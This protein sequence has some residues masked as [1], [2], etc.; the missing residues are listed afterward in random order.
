MTQDTSAGDTLT[1]GDSSAGDREPHHGDGDISATAT[2]VPPP[3]PNP[4]IKAPKRLLAPCHPLSP[5]ASLR[6]TPSP[7]SHLGATVPRCH[8]AAI[9]MSP[10]SHLGATL[11]SLGH[12]LVPLSCNLAAIL[13]PLCCRQAA[14]LVPHPHGVTWQ[15]S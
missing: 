14:I 8:P 10:G 11:M 3:A 9:L 7:G 12:H 6:V 2:P 13:V 4:P 15:P 5:T 1:H